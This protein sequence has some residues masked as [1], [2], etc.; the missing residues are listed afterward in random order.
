MEYY[1]PLYI[2]KFDNLYENVQILR[3]IQVIKTDEEEI[4]NP[5]VPIFITE[6]E[7]VTKIFHT[8]KKSLQDWI[9]LAINSVKCLRKK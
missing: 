3:K 7:F 6:S 2:N 4:E 1:E 9:A 8:K 5:N